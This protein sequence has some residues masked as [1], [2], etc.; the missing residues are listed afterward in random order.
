[1]AITTDSGSDIKLACCSLKWNHLSCFS[2]NLDLAVNKGLN[3]PRVDWVLSLCKKVVA[4]FSYSW[5]QNSLP[6]KS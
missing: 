5:K 1:M 2:H 6:Q 4:T 3:D